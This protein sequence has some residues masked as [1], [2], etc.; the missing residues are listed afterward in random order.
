LSEA[1]HRPPAGR[2]ID[3][4]PWIA[5]GSIAV[6]CVVMAIKYAA[7]LKTGS[8]A[9]YSDAL[10]SIVNV[11]TAI[12]A[13]IAV[14]IS[15]RPADRHHQFGHHKAEYFSAVVEGALIIVAA[16]FILREAWEAVQQPRTIEQPGF[17]LMLNGAATVIN[18]VWS[19]CLLSF[20][21]KLK[22]PALAADGWHLLTD[23]LT[24]VGVIA[25]LLLATVTGWRLIDPALAAAVA[26]YILYAGWVLARD[27]VSGL[28]DV[29]VTSE[30][31]RRIRAIISSNAEGAIEAHDLRTRSA[32]R[33]TFIEFH[34]VVPGTMPVAEAHRICDR[35]EEA[36]GVEVPGAEVLIHV[37]PEGEARHRGIVVV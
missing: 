8:V 30:E 29:A 26:A 7:Y 13:F 28:M 9:L 24:S 21:R 2:G 36:I 14:R 23:V 20:G 1:D 37:E 5:A 19:A 4:M 12:A 31:S 22:S 35:L 15:V 32:G 3:Y 11:V 34:L 25:G 18:A 6:A 33:V 16:I 17:G 27:S 10:E